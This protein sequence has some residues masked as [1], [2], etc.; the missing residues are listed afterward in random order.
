MCYKVSI[1][2]QH[3]CNMTYIFEPSTMQTH[4]NIQNKKVS[5]NSLYPI[6]RHVLQNKFSTSRYLKNQKKAK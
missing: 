1:K 6:N 3:N 5:A 2:K 4:Q